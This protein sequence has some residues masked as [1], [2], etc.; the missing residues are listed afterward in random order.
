MARWLLFCEAVGDFRTTSG[1]VDRVLGE[2]GPR[3]VAELLEHS[4]EGVRE[5]VP[6]D[7]GN[8]FFDVH[9]LYK[10]T[11][12][13]GLPMRRGFFGERPGRPGA[14][15]VFH[16]VRLAECLP[17]RR[18]GQAVP[19]GMVVVWDMDKQGD[20]RREGLTQGRD[21]A[22]Q[23]AGAAIAVVLGSPDPNR[24]AWVLA[25]FT[26]QN[27]VEEARLEA[28]HRALG[29]WPN[30]AP[31]ALGAQDER[32]TKNTKRVLRAVLG[33]DPEREAR[34]WTETPLAVLSERGAG[35]GLTDFLAE[36]EEHLLPQVLRR[37]TPA[38]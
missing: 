5:W 30:V 4:P 27:E 37:A 7:H 28:E 22:R 38:R 20:D 17:Q 31:E 15:M 35:C 18:P 34:C 3:W 6:D 26:P 24:E 12:A 19:D 33:A 8:A 9:D 36:V 1:L 10:T 2:R 21:E 29:F 32:A 11:R 23:L 25:G 13:W 14:T 16:A